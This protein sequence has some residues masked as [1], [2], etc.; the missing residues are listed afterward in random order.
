MRVEAAV[1]V[2]FTTRIEAVSSAFWPV[3]AQ[4]L[5]GKP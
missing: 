2:A 4:S 1:A 3:E 5:G